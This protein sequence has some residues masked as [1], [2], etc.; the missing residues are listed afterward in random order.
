MRRF[1]GYLTLLL[2]FALG[3]AMAMLHPTSADVRTIHAAWGMDLADPSTVAGFADF[4]VVGEVVASMADEDESYTRHEVRVSEW[5][6]G[7]TPK[8]IHVSQLGFVDEEGAIAQTEHQPL[9]RSGDTYVL[10][11]AAPR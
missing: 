3:G 8:V 1:I 4:I 6:K 7:R 5:L 11:L 10:A 9:L 2:A